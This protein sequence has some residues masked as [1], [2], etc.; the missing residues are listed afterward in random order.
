MKIKLR[1]FSQLLP[2]LEPKVEAKPDIEEEVAKITEHKA[3]PE[4]EEKPKPTTLDETLMMTEM[5]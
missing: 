5:I 4:P 2:S 3:L 1:L